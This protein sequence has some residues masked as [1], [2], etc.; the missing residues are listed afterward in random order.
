MLDAWGCV[1]EGTAS[2]YYEIEI[3]PISV[4][5]PAPATPIHDFDEPETT[6]APATPIHWSDDPG[7][8]GGV[9]AY[10]AASEVLRYTPLHALCLMRETTTTSTGQWLLLWRMS[11][12]LEGAHRLALRQGDL[13]PSS[14]SHG[15]L[16]SHTRALALLRAAASLEAYDRFTRIATTR[17]LNTATREYMGLTDWSLSI[18]ESTRRTASALVRTRRPSPTSLTLTRSINTA[19]SRGPPPVRLPLVRPFPPRLPVRPVFPERQPG[20]HARGRPNHP[21]PLT[22]PLQHQSIVPPTTPPAPYPRVGGRRAGG[23]V[24]ALRSGGVPS[25]S[26][27][28][29]AVAR[30]RPRS[31]AHLSPSSP[32]S[33]FRGPSF[34]PLRPPSRTGV[35]LLPPG[36]P[37]PLHRGGAP[38][39]LRILPRVRRLAPVVG[40]VAGESRAG[41]CPTIGPTSPRP[42]RWRPPDIGRR[43]CSECPART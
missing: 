24:R 3:S 19:R 41:A 10:D 9:A 14:D 18:D 6:S 27:D 5:A 30:R 35:V 38:R 31:P 2:P 23:R 39:E 12:W 15:I 36:R 4:A 13:P 43:Y 20:P 29:R 33:R 22:H 37:V 28:L 42:S 21:P 7:P 11:Y 1:M 17:V 26:G 8:P 34:R 40:R 25:P 32:S 16:A